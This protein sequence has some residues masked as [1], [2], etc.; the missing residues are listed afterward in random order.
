MPIVEIP[1]QGQVEFPDTMSDDEI[2]KVINAERSKVLPSYGP[3]REALAG[4]TFGFSPKMEPML[5]GA[6]TGAP[7][8]QQ[9]QDVQAML[10]ARDQYRELNPVESTVANIAGSL[11]T[12]LIPGVAAA[13]V[14]SGAG[15][16]GKAGAAVVGGAVPG[17]LYG[18]GE[19]PLGQ[20]DSGAA[21]GGIIG[22]AMGPVGGLLGRGAVGIGRSLGGVTNRLLGS[23]R[24]AA[25]QR[26]AA[27]VLGRLQAAGIDPQSLSPQEGQ[28][29]AELHPELARAAGYAVRRSPEVSARVVPEIEQRQAQRQ[30]TLADRLRKEASGY[31]VSLLQA[32]DALQQMQAAAA[33]Y[34]QSAYQKAGPIT[35]PD[36]LLSRP[37]VQRGLGIL[38]QMQAERGLPTYPPGSALTLEGADMLKRALD[39][40][41]YSNRA[42]TSGVGKNLLKD[43]QDTRTA[44]VSA[45]D[46]Q[47]PAEYQ[48]A[49]SIFAGPAQAREALDSGYRDGP[50]MTGE[51]LTRYLSGLSQ[52]EQQA[53]RIG[54]GNALREKVLQNPRTKNAASAIEQ[55]P[56]AMS[57]VQAVA[58]GLL[59]DIR[60]MANA[61]RVESGLLGGSQTAE[62]QAIDEGLDQALQTGIA[63]RLGESRSGYIMRQ[64]GNVVDRSRFGGERGATEIGSL[65]LNQDLQRNRATIQRLTD[66]SQM[67]QSQAPL[68]AGSVGFGAGLLGGQV[69]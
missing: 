10:A 31:D 44:L 51:E 55:R 13:K 60:T 36:A 48:T 18:A 52:S 64:L 1:G 26:A 58:P 46:A 67:L 56:A 33:P 57:Q 62:R 6:L 66:L 40:V 37:S 12:A 43:M 9:Y 22:A 29:L 28:Y 3:G 32:D 27:A 34:Y 65:L 53:F 2:A 20:E 19:A 21:Q 69:Q 7:L 15:M 14:A 54:M 50:K 4:A 59:G 23:P 39:D 5:K 8:A 49:R 30:L 25:E 61:G 24:P 63:P 16:L 68:N 47:A 17:A 38:N 42:P 11:P 35:I 41:L 45:I